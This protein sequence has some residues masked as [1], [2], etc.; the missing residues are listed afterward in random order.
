MRD[1]VVAIEGESSAFACY[2]GVG[3][4]M[5]RPC[6]HP[7]GVVGYGDKHEAV[8]PQQHK[9]HQQ[10]PPLHHHVLLE[11]SKHGGQTRES[12]TDGEARTVRCSTMTTKSMTTGLQIALSMVLRL[13]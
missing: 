6:T 7:G 12:Q 1:I 3:V 10:R 4:C 13:C 9:Q 11:R 8:Q 2:Y 5:L